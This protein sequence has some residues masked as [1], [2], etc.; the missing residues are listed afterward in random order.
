MVKA[1]VVGLPELAGPGFLKRLP[2]SLLD[3]DLF[4]GIGMSHILG[5]KWSKFGRKR[6]I[7]Q[8]G[9]YLLFLFAY[10][11]CVVS[12][13]NRETEINHDLSNYYISNPYGRS[14]AFMW[15]LLL[16]LDAFLLFME[17]RQL[18]N[19]G[20]IKYFGDPWSYL[21][22]F[23]YMTVPIVFGFHLAGLYAQYPVA[24]LNTISSCFKVPNA[25]IRL[26]L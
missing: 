18:A 1:Y 19:I 5:Y 7:L 9:T 17:F 11:Y 26:L 4:A 14:H 23:S 10:I 6:F 25:P 20:S 16:L 8:I 21:D 2:E 24:A 13:V 12:M 15:A 22:M 3:P